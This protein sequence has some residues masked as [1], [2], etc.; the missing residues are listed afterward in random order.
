MAERHTI[1]QINH[2]FSIWWMRFEL[3]HKPYHT[4]WKV[5]W[6]VLEEAV[7]NAL[8]LRRFKSPG[9]PECR[10]S[11]NG[12]ALV[13]EEMEMDEGGPAGG[14]NDGRAEDQDEEENG[15]ESEEDKEQLEEGDNHGS[16]GEAPSPKKRGRPKKKS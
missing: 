7:D 5:N 15:E 3:E 10:L 8:V 13:L 1:M 12:G 11:P 9:H 16:S 6:A 4:G 14:G 2:L